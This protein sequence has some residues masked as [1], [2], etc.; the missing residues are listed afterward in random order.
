MKIRDNA[1]VDNEGVNYVRTIFERHKCLF[2]EFQLKNDYGID[3]IIEVPTGDRLLGNLIALQIKSGS[4]YCTKDHCFIPGDRNHF[5]YWYNYSLP[6]IGIVYDPAEKTAYWQDIKQFLKTKS[7]MIERGPY[8]IT[9]EKRYS[10]KMNDE[11]FNSFIYHI[12]SI[13]TTL[14]FELSMMYVKSNDPQKRSKGMSSL[15]RDH[16]QNIQTWNFLFD[17]FNSSKVGMLDPAIVYAFSH[18]SY[19]P[20]LFLTDKTV[21]TGNLQKTLERR[22]LNFTK[23]DFIKLLSVIDD[24]DQFQRGDFSEAV[25]CVLLPLENRD[26]IFKQIIND[27]DLPTQIRL[28]ALNFFSHNKRIEIVPFL[29]ELINKKDGLE[30]QALLIR[31]IIDE[32]GDCFFYS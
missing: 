18:I 19:N 9:F 31:D 6:V 2:H 7:E 25:I 14:N 16:L 27:V 21:I 10:Y 26:K 23:E 30:E 29:E 1:R 11:D 24:G 28:S 17:E 15:L 8:R 32:Y 3:A 22:I 4:S 13:S 5:E 20:D 12:T